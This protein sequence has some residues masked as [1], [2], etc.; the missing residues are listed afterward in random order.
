MLSQLIERQSPLDAISRTEQQT[1]LRQIAACRAREKRLALAI[2]D[3]IDGKD[4]QAA[5]GG[6]G[7]GMPMSVKDGQGGGEVNEGGGGEGAM[8][9]GVP[10][11]GGTPKL[12]PLHDGGTPT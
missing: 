12:E 10:R 8:P 1:L 2:Q 3:R 7:L 11:D 4:G 9:V 6:R 5:A